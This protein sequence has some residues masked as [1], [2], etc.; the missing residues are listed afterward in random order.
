[1]TKRNEEWSTFKTEVIQA[2]VGVKQ[3]IAEIKASVKQDIAE[4]KTAIKQEIAEVKVFVKQEIADNN[5]HIQG[6]VRQE[7]QASE[8]RLERKITETRDEVLSGVA[9]MID[10]SI[11]PQIDNHELR[12]IKLEIKAA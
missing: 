4:V 7:I 11:L 5:R 6:L 9:E 3:G 2:I 12:L 10:D 1:M 8:R